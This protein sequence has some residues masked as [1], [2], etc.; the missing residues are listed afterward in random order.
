MKSAPIPSSRPPDDVSGQSLESDEQKRLNK[1]WETPAT[2]YG[3]LTTVDHKTLG[4]RYIITAFAFFAAGGIEALIMRM[5]LVKPDNHLVGPQAYNELFT[6]HGVTMMFLFIQPVLS[7]LS[8]YLTPLMIGAREL[9]FPRLNSF[10]Y[11]A[12]LFAGLLIY[13]SFLV[14]AAPNAGWFNYTPLASKQFN[15]GP[16]IDFYTIGLLFLGV[17]TTAGAVNSVVSILKL[18]AP[19]MSLDRMPLFLWSSLT[20]SLAILMAM[21]ALSASLIFLELERNWGFHFF[22]PNGGGSALLW[23]HLFWV[24]GHPWVYIV[25]LPATGMLS[26]IIPAFCRRPMIGHTIV[27]L[28]T[29]MTGLIGFGVWV[30]HMFATGLPQLSIG[31][32]AA[33]SMT[34]SIPSAMTIAVWVVTLWY[35]R[36]V[37]TTPMLFALAFIAQFVIGGITGVMTAAVPFDWQATDTYFIVAHLHYVLA[38]GTLFGVMAALYYWF[39]KMSGRM[40]DEAL[41][42]WS[43]W[44]LFIGFNLTFFPMHISGLLGMPRRVYTYGAWENLA[45]PNLLSTLGTFLQAVAILV[46]LVNILRSRKRGAVAGDNPWRAGTL[47]WMTT[48]PPPE[49]NFLN[50]PLVKSRY[51]LWTKDVESGPALSNDR[52]TASTSVL[53]AEF[54]GPV[55]LPEGS[56]WPVW[57]AVG[58]LVTCSA[59][60]ARMNIVAVVGAVLT[61]FSVARWVRPGSAVEGNGDIARWGMVLLCVTEAALFAYFLAGYFY[62]GVVNSAWPPPG[63][64]KPSLTLPLIMTLVLVSSSA[65]L[66]VADWAIG[67]GRTMLYRIGVVSTVLLGS[68]FLT[69]QAIEYTGELKHGG[70]TMHAYLSMFYTITGFHGVHVFVGLLLISWALLQELRGYVTSERPAYARNVSV[71]WH[72]VDAV[73]LVILTVLY[74]TPRLYN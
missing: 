30:H 28:S 47:E 68:G 42:K 35:G 3:W 21:P 61:A 17:A 66:T 58:L 64:E 24:F 2:L 69:L 13:G 45:L 41:G 32:F 31:F 56:L 57:V 12:F 59:L 34:V 18:R 29:V 5:Q 9:A 67:R 33:A 53:D 49:Y 22:D 46:L 11:Y 43:F 10:S 44:L 16:N 36:V 55:Y 63:I 62:L 50:A 19:G 71:Y 40:L 72:F 52:L 4:I 37:L 65:T 51:P 7:G 38:G 74:L 48:S 1:L 54:A 26:M 6:M 60:L 25:F 14:S 15:A 70:P 8:F 20:T 39:P 73:W 27:A 23:Q